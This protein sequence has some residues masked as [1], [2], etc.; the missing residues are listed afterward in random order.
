MV[1][2]QCNSI[3]SG[4]AGMTELGEEKT[5]APSILGLVNTGWASPLDRLDTEFGVARLV[6]LTHC[7]FHVV[8]LL[9]VA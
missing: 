8:S 1:A 4:I 5:I 7:T 6:S 3:A 2:V 9:R